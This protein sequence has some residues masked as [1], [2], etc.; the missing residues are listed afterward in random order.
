MPICIASLLDNWLTIS[1]RFLLLRYLDVQLGTT[2]CIKK[3]ENLMKTLQGFY[4]PTRKP[5]KKKEKENRQNNLF[6]LCSAHVTQNQYCPNKVLHTLSLL[7]NYVSHKQ[8]LPTV[9][10]WT[11][12]QNRHCVVISTNVWQ[13][14]LRQSR[15][16]LSKS[17]RETDGAGEGET[18]SSR[19]KTE[20]SILWNTFRKLQCWAE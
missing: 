1:S 18:E 6:S 5:N 13:V 3:K 20:D 8:S 12:T 4:F 14:E 19:S 2:W 10:P 9:P 11:W 15:Q 7:C 17:C 16:P